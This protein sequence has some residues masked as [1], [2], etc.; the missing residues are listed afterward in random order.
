MAVVT[1]VPFHFSFNRHGLLNGMFNYLPWVRRPPSHT[2]K[3][4]PIPVTICVIF[5]SAERMAYLLQISGL[6]Q[7]TLSS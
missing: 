5:L 4:I 7:E 2:I 1:W 3:N 6:N